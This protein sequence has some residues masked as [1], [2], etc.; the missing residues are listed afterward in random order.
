M[1]IHNYVHWLKE[2]KT[3]KDLNREHFGPI[4]ERFTSSMNVMVPLTWTMPI[5]SLCREGWLRT[6]SPALSL[7][8]NLRTWEKQR[9]ETETVRQMRRWQEAAVR[10]QGFTAQ[11]E[12]N[13]H[14][15]SDKR[16]S[17]HSMSCETFSSKETERYLILR[18]CVACFPVQYTVQ[19][20]NYLYSHI[21]STDTTQL[22]TPIV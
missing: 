6:R 15:L 4:L 20:C 13:P 12:Q 17:V 8:T 22:L 5:C 10:E 3:E 2:E 21:N 11:R 14:I 16:K 18:R 19:K 1:I 9:G 7:A